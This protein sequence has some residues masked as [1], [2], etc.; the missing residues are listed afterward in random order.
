MCTYILHLIYSGGLYEIKG[1]LLTNT[2]NV[3]T[4][5]RNL[6]SC[7]FFFKTNNNQHGKCWHC[8]PG[9]SQ[10][11]SPGRYCLQETLRSRHVWSSKPPATVVLI[12]WRTKPVFCLLDMRHERD[13]CVMNTSKL[14][15]CLSFFSKRPHLTLPRHA[16]LLNV[17]LRKNI[18]IMT[19]Q[20]SADV[21]YHDDM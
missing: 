16:F 11:T 4:A 7:L 5:K 6:L 18:L 2:G 21:D 1:D 10:S 15:Q 9:L 20:F 3:V 8:Y 13:S 17:N 12:R 14:S 19:V